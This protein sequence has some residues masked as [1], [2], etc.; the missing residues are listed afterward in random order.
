MLSKYIVEIDGKEIEVTTSKA[1]VLKLVT[2]TKEFME[3]VS[4]AHYKACSCC[5]S[6]WDIEEHITFAKRR[7][8]DHFLGPG[9]D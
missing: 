1:S 8:V 7:F 3:D 2:V 5:N 9:D 6:S 4:T